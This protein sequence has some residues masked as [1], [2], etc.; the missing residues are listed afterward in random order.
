MN[1]AHAAFVRLVEIPD[2]D[3]A[4]L[5]RA[6]VDGFDDER[7][8]SGAWRPWDAYEKRKLGDRVGDTDDLLRKS[9]QMR[10]TSPR[11]RRGAKRDGNRTTTL[12]GAL[13]EALC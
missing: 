8:F 10:L 1:R 3:A 2:G 13:L 7:V 9:H 11:G 6:T 5:T 4:A 12:F